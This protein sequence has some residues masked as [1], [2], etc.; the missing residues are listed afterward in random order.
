MVGPGL[1]V[2][3]GEFQCRLERLLECGL[4][5]GSKLLIQGDGEG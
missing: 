2:G 1:K 3:Y 5:V 4:E